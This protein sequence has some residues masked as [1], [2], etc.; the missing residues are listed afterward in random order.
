LARKEAWTKDNR[1]NK[2]QIIDTHIKLTEFGSK[3]LQRLPTLQ[4]ASLFLMAA[5]S[6]S[7]RFG[8]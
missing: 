2:K 6:E 3:G 7:M 1:I 5:P 8:R 4:K